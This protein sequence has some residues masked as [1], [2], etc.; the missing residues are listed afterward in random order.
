VACPV[1]DLWS[2]N[3]FCSALL[4]D[5]MEWKIVQLKL[6]SGFFL[7]MSDV[8]VSIAYMYVCMHVY[9]E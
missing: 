5:V 4:C 3:K 2:V 6:I 7:F 1:N 9:I 8:A